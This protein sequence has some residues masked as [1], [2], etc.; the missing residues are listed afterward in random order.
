MREGYA[1]QRGTLE[2]VRGVPAFVGCSLL[3]RVLATPLHAGKEMCLFIGACVY[4][5]WLSVA[6][7]RYT[8]TRRN[9][10]SFCYF[11]FFIR[12]LRGAY[13]LSWGV[14]SVA[15]TRY[16]P[17]R[18]NLYLCKSYKR[19]LSLGA[20]LPGSKLFCTGTRQKKKF[21][22]SRFSLFLAYLL[23]TLYLWARTSG[24]MQKLLL[25]L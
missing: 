16:T 20:Y 21:L 6:C 13:P 17:T 5:L 15:R 23:S 3:G 19:V 25:F 7:T 8:P 18:R 9:R 11:V 22:F 24:N 12:P 10:N 14:L 2:E 4:A 1:P